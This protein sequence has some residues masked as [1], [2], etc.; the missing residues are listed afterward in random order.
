MNKLYCGD[1]LNW[2]K[3]FESNLVDL[4][5]LDPPFQSGKNYNMI[6]ATEAKKRKGSTAQ[7][8]AFEDTWEWG[9]ESEREYHGLLDG[10]L[11]REKPN[12]RLIT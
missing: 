3:R 7:I 8:Q 12:P 5:Y 1:N 10:S 11:L 4:I 2:L 6:F 9:D